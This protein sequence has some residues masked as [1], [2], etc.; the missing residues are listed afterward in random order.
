MLKIISGH[1]EIDEDLCACFIEGQNAF[2]HV[3]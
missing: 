3:K 1:L 2:D